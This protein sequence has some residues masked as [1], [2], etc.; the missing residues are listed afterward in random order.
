MNSPVNSSASTLRVTVLGC[1]SSGGVPL[2][3][4]N[5]GACNPDNPRNRRRR[6]SILIEARGQTLLIDTGPDLREQLIMA[7]P[8]R[9]DAVIYT[10]SHA[11][12]IH[13]VDDLRFYV[14]RQRAQIPA[15]MDA[16]THQEMQRKFGYLF[17]E[18]AAGMPY[19]PLIR[20][21]PLT[22]RFCIA[23]LEIESFPQ[24]HGNII[25][26]GLKLGRFAYS[27][28][29][30]DLPAT[31]LDRLRDAKLDVWIVDATRAEPHP[32]HAHVAMALDWMEHVKPQRG[33]LTHLSTMLDYD[34]LCAQLPD[35]VRPLYDGLVIE[36]PDRDHSDATR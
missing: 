27:T 11:D 36:V 9:I 32:A 33:F 1:G 4:G 22:P 17:P 20:Y 3:T 34:A 28:D 29:C 6:A 2:A 23:E 18:G 10:H 8:E 21:Q 24:P 31:T 7:Q 16:L 5:W 25:S 30:V 35:F 14:Y 19:P 15:Y 12:H 13:G 26:Q